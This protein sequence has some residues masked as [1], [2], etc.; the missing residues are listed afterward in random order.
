MSFPLHP[1][2]G[3]GAAVNILP[4]WYVCMNCVKCIM[5]GKVFATYVSR[6]HFSSQVDTRSLDLELWFISRGLAVCFNV[7]VW[8]D[9]WRLHDLTWLWLFCTAPNCARELYHT[10]M[11]CPL[12]PE[13][14]AGHTHQATATWHFSSIWP[15]QKTKC[16]GV[17]HGCFRGRTV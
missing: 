6:S 16:Q 3:T 5:L 14:H 12:T 9:L 4:L 8:P 15:R 10:Y 11:P 13:S 7:C 1:G 17:E 2:H